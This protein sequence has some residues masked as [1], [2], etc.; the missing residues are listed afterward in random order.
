MSTA[1]LVS[2]QEY[3]TTT[4]RPDRDYVDG[5]LRTGDGRLAMGMSDLFAAND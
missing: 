2:L 1:A 3:L 5:V 4:Y